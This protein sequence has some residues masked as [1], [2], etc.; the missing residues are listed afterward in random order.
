MKP[1]SEI[2]YKH[3][4]EELS[5]NYER[6]YELRYPGRKIW[7]PQ[8]GRKRGMRGYTSPADEGVL[9]LMNEIEGEC[10]RLIRK[11]ER[12]TGGG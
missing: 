1:P 5:E 11:A 10:Q 12:Y 2:R 8:M 7:L 4:V 9:D 6:L 3:I